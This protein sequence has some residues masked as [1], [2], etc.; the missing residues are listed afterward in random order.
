MLF[1]EIL[2]TIDNTTYRSSL[3]ASHNVEKSQFMQYSLYAGISV[4][5]CILLVI[6][7]SKRTK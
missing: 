7:L 5:I 4:I 6:L 2:Y 3:L 1:G